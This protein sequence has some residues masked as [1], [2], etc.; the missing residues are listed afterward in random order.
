MAVRD[1]PQKRYTFHYSDNWEGHSLHQVVQ[2]C[3][4][5]LG[6]RGA[7]LAIKNG[8]VSDKDHEDEGLT[9]GRAAV[10]AGTDLIVDLRHGVQGR[11]KPKHPR[12]HER[13]KVFYDDEHIIVISKRSG[14]VSQELKSGQRSERAKGPSATELIKTYL[15]VQKKPVVEPILVQRLDLGTSGLMVVAKSAHAAAELQKQFRP[16]RVLTREYLAFV[17]GWLRTEKGTWKSILGEGGD[18]LKKTVSQ[19]IAGKGPGSKRGRLAVTHYQIE[20]KFDDTCLLRLR[21]ETGRTHQIRIHCAEA[22]HPILG[23]ELYPK[24]TERIMDA[25]AKQKLRPRNNN[26]PY[27]ESQALISEGILKI[28]PQ[29]HTRRMALHCTKL[30]FFHP[31]TGKKMEF[32][33]P[34]PEDLEK[35]AARLRGK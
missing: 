12:L 11:G 2:L 19:D 33:A 28:E 14:T 17:T 15:K 31:I 9:D 16:P 4:P 35:L 30:K 24:L 23:D 3:L 8:L 1:V 22:G 34:L 32:E 13:I 27:N 29:S 18:G 6:S 5:D 20:E 26:S 7:M 25:L 21:L 10:A